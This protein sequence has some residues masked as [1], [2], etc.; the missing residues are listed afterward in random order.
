VQNLTENDAEYITIVVKH[1]F[2]SVIILQ[3]EIQ[4]TLEDQILSNVVV[5]VTNFES[6]FGLKYKGAIPLHED[7]QIKYNEKR[8]AYLILSSEE[9][10]TPYPS[11]KIS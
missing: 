1:V 6:A 7:E 4:N 5:K 9:C 8:Y 10:Q 11:V 2:E 3:Y